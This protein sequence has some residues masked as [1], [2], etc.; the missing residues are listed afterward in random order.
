MS[1]TSL[2]T[3]LQ[4]VEQGL[5]HKRVLQ[6]QLANQQ[7]KSAKLA[8][9]AQD[10]TDATS[11]VEALINE[12]QEHTLQFLEDVTALLLKHTFGDDYDFV[13]EAGVIYNKPA[14]TPKVLV[15]KQVLSL[16]GEVGGGVL[17]V[18]SLGMRL[19]RW[20]ISTNKTA[21][22]FI[23]DEP[24]RFLSRN[25][26]P[27]FAVA[28]KELCDILGLQLIIITHSEALEAIADVLIEVEKKNQVSQAYIIKTNRKGDKR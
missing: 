25:L 3:C 15:G 20:A 8:R 16:R 28:L 12:H 5:E 9:Q 21:P 24:T 18:V 19:G 13:L 4:A 17:D 22:T 14:V 10:I 7:R 27:L 6:A 26:Q 23:L 11:F 2:R 1:L